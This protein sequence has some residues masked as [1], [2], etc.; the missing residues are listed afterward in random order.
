MIFW[1]SAHSKGIADSA[2]FHT[3]PQ[4]PG[5]FFGPME[6]Q[7]DCEKSACFVLKIARRQAL[8]VLSSS[9]GYTIG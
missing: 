2:P 9:G 6:Q 3:P 5:E 8:P 1:Q 4:F 7:L